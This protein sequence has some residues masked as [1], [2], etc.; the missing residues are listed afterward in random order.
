MPVIQSQDGRV[1]AWSGIQAGPIQEYEPSGGRSPWVRYEAEVGTGNPNTAKVFVRVQESWRKLVP[2]L[3]LTC[4]L[5]EKEV[6]TKFIEE[7][8]TGNYPPLEPGVAN[9]F[10]IKDLEMV[11]RYR[12]LREG[13]GEGKI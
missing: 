12:K 4:Q 3:A 8:V 10:C 6:V 5:A 13:N 11:E 1:V 9:N 7:R 2:H